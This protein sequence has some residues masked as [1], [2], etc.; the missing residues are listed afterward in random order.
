MEIHGGSGTKNMNSLTVIILTYNE[1]IHIERC[2][3]SAQSVSNS[4]FVVDSNSSDRTVEIAQSLGASVWKHEFINH[5]D[6]FQW[7]LDNLPV[8]TEWVMR[9]DADKY[10]EPGLVNK[11]QQQLPALPTDIDGIYIKR[12]VFFM[13]KWIRHGG[14]YPQIVMRIWRVGKGHIEQ[15]WMDEHIV[16]SAGSKTTMFDEHLVDDDHKG[17]TFWINK[18]NKYAS[19]EAVDL[20]N[21]K[22]GFMPRDESLNL[23]SGNPQAKRK[24]VIKEKLY[25]RLPLGLRAGLYFLFRYIFYFGFMDGVKGWVY[26]FLQAFWYRFLV[27]IKINELEE[28][29]HGNVEEIKRLLREQHGLDIKP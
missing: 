20:L 6:Q 29:S 27:D 24:R 19:R 11:I 28:R 9:L 2:I 17:I 1:E 13:S 21:L 8:N 25:S 16:V 4:V 3:R 14:F 15:R 18:H 12:K 26:H 22:Y 23:L 7:A 5:A 10:L